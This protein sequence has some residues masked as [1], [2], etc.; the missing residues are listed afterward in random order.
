MIRAKENNLW[1][2]REEGKITFV[3]LKGLDGCARLVNECTACAKAAIA[4]WP[5]H[6]FLFEL[7]DQ[8]VGRT[9]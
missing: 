2:S 7:A 6:E 1:K 4:D 5:E 3:D 8:M 9:V